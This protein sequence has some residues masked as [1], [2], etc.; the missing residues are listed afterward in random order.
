MCTVSVIIP[1]YNAAST[2]P[3]ALDSVLAQTFR[4]S[5][6]IVIDDGST[7]NTQVVL[8]PYFDKIRYIYQLNQERSAAR[9]R[10]IAAANGKYI[11]FL[12]ADDWW[13]PTKLERQVK[14]LEADATIGL[15]YNERLMV[16]PDGAISSAAAVTSHS[17]HFHFLSFEALLF[18]DWAGSPSQVMV[19]A[20][21]LA[22]TG[23]FNHNLRQGEDW[24][25]WL[26]IACNYRVAC[27]SEALT[28]YQLSS[29]GNLFRLI[30]R[31]GQSAYEYML[32]KLFSQPQ[33]IDRYAHLEAP[34]AGTC[35]TT[36]RIDRLRPSRNEDW[37]GEACPW[38]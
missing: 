17:N 7:D 5:E 22:V 29:E 8:A 35:C 14:V 32:D 16:S 11:A 6:V 20:N 37:S 26:R 15:V 31:G 18:R 33:I 23:N 10:G 24:D 28:C 13:L 4:E 36:G 34:R 25:L 19:P 3:R 21:V 9:N 12:D 27:I 2:L 30:N 1:A 38:Q